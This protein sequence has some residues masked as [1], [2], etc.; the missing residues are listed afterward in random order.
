MAEICLIP[1]PS[2]PLTGPE[3][4]RP[5][6]LL[7]PLAKA[8]ASILNTRITR[9]QTQH[10]AGCLS[11]PQPTVAWLDAVD[12]AFTHCHAVRG[13]SAHNSRPYI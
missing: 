12:R 11:T 3:A 7:P 5:I 8:L 10:L 6:S 2:K 9:I 1:K 13:Y 4:L